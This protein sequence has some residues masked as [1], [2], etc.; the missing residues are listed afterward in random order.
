MR[1]KANDPVHSNSPNPSLSLAILQNKHPIGP[2]IHHGPVYE[3]GCP[4][5]GE[6]ILQ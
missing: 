1:S 6:E 4:A 2:D 3:L 5:R